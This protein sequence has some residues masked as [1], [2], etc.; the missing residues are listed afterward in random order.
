MSTPSYQQL[1]D[2][3]HT[4][5]DKYG[6]DDLLTGYE[7]DLINLLLQNHI[8]KVRAA[9]SYEKCIAMLNQALSAHLQRSVDV[10]Y[11]ITK[12]QDRHE[13]YDLFKAWKDRLEAEMASPRLP[14][15]SITDA[16]VGLADR[17]L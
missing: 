5:A 3:V 7:P 2:A 17:I 10:N 12:E 14:M 1:L 8:E 9:N 13:L 15:P 16:P 11:F 6:M 4:M